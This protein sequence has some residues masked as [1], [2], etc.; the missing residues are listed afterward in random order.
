MQIT[1]VRIR[2][3]FE[4]EGCLRAIAS[5]TLDDAFAVHDLK[6]IE[7]NGRLFV[8]MPS[9][10]DGAGAYRDIAHPVGSGF[11]KELE[12]AVLDA[13]NIEMLLCSLNN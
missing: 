3:I 1:D 6:I 7:G 5:I 13:F 12:T 4:D 9:R 10:R 8:A 11:R 2:K